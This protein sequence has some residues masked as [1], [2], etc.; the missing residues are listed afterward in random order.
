MRCMGETQT[1]KCFA[2]LESHPLAAG[3]NRLNLIC[4]VRGKLCERLFLLLFYH[5]IYVPCN[6]ES[7]VNGVGGKKNFCVFPLTR[8]KTRGR[9]QKTVEKE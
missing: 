9:M 2:R 6:G 8:G 4:A 1:R 7:F 3:E 5:I